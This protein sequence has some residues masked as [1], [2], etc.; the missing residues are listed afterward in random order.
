M[1]SPLLQGTHKVSWKPES[2]A[3]AVIQV[4]GAQTIPCRFDPSRSMLKYVV[5]KSTKIKDKEKILSAPRQKQQ[6]TYNKSPKR[7]SADKSAEV[8]QARKEWHNESKVMQ[9]KSL[10]A[11]VPYPVRPAVRFGEGTGSFIN[12]HKLREFSRTKPVLQQILKELLYSGKKK[13]T[14]RNRIVNGK[15]HQ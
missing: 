8:L 15:A 6:I 14:I 12:Q 11:R 9:L 3:K 7:L 4:H 5:I 10:Q 13:S 2:R 1:Q